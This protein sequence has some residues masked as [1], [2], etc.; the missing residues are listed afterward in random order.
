MKQTT[1]VAIILGVL[2]LISVLQAFQL[3]GLKNKIV[4]GQLST[5]SSSTTTRVAT[6]SGSGDSGRAAAL[7]SSIKNLPQMVGGC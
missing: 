6:S 7:P 5:G 4:E 1:L 2:V 3:T